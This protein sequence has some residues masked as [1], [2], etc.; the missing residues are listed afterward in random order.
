VE[1]QGLNQPPEAGDVFSVVE[2][3][4]T[5]REISEYRAKLGRDAAVIAAIR[6]VEQLFGAVGG[7]KQ[8]SVIV[9]GDV[10]GS[11]EAIAASIQKF[12]GDEV[13]LKILHTGVGAISESDVQLAKASGATIIGFNVR[14]GS[15][16]K[17]L[18]AREKVDVRYYS[19]IYDVVDDVKAA[20]SG[21]LSPG[22]KENFIGYAEIR[23]VFNISKAGKVGGCMVTEGVVRRGA[24]VRLLRDNV[25][26][27]EGMLKTL[28]RFKDEV[29]EVKAGFECGMA[30]E[31]YED[32]REGDVIEAFEV[33]QVARSV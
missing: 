9:K 32:I 6:P 29:K 2:D 4:K 16:A 33:E 27:H 8:F 22:I 30:F 18:A 10:Q 5:A 23:Q 7:K 24:K 26:I 3:E 17:D 28:K 13:A 14:A 12:S 11:V 15:K 1:I 25:V 31:N 19:V 20:L 21:L